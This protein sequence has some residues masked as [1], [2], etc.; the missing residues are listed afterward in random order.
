MSMADLSSSWMPSSKGIVGGIQGMGGAV[1]DLFSF[2]GNQASSANDLLAAS[3]DTLA[4]SSYTKAAG[5]A[6]DNLTIEEQSVA[7]KEMQADREI[8]K[9]ESAQRATT[10]ANG[11]QESGSAAAILADSASQGA[12]QKSLIQQQGDI[13]L[14]AT[15]QQILALNTQSQEATNQATMQTNAANAA[16]TAGIGNLIGGAFKAVSSIASLALL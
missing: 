12:L 4:A 7:I 6:G 14:N 9:N 10:A 13:A 16:D 8:Y 3:N 2:E 5:L 11:F 15:K 1:Q